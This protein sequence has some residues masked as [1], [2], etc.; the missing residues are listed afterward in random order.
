MNRPIARRLAA[1]VSALSS[2]R[3]PALWV[4][5]FA[6][7]LAGCATPVP[8]TSG[9]VPIDTSRSAKGQDSR[10]LF[11]ILHYTVADLP[12]SLKVLT[13]H[14][15]SAH[16]V[17]SDETPPRIFRLVD[18]SRRAWH[19]GPS[20]WKGHRML[21][22]SSIGIEIVHPGYK[23]GPDGQ[24]VYQPFPQAQVQ[25][26]IPLVQDI[27]QR[28]RIRPDRILG[29]GEVSPAYKEDPGPTFPWRRLA[30]LGIT[31]PWPDPS[32]VAAQRERFE[33]LLPDTAWFQRT[34]AQH[35][36]QVEATGQM[37]E[38]TQRVLMN[39]QMRY[40]PERYDGAPDAETAALLHVLTHPVKL[41]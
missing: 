24:R 32:R 19:S 16:Y 27:V 3:L 15:V 11:L 41:P 23:P 17:V 28:H 33:A 2:V 12:I 29:H 14:E 40:R 7:L 1:L 31:P 30:D 21:N 5:L 18:E 25:A 20:A 38:Q 10:V 4:T 34:L 22:A 37:D 36:Y 26:L 9:G 13:E 8:T 35:G 6:V 39:F